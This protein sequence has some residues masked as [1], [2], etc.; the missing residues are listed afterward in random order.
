M[1]RLIKTAVRYMTIG[2]LFSQWKS[3]GANTMECLIQTDVELDTPQAIR[4]LL[5]RKIEPEHLAH[6]PYAIS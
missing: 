2:A 3:G 4:Q 5:M 6:E 1:E